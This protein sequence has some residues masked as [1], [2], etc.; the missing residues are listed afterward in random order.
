MPEMSLRELLP[1]GSI[2]TGAHVG[3]WRAAIRAVGDLLVADGATTD[4]YTEQMLAT[5]D[6]FGPY[7]VIAP[8]LA[9]AHS[10]PSEAVL[11]TAMSWASLAEPVEFG[12]PQND[13]VRL[14]VGLAAVDHTGHS[15]ALARLAR[16]LAQPDRLHTL[17]EAGDP[18]TVHTII[19]EYEEGDA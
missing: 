6:E 5:V 3:D 9:L 17:T 15:A 12:H 7:I 11:R 18:A 1:A 2:V 16:M 19:T 4:A 13:P 14:V 10:R 8:G